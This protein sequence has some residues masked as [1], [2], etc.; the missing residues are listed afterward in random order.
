MLIYLSIFV[1]P[2]CPI[3]GRF[4]AVYQIKHMLHRWYNPPS[5]SLSLN[6]AVV[7]PRRVFKALAEKIVC[8]KYRV[9]SSNKKL[10]YSDLNPIVLTYINSHNQLYT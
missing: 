3:A 1:L 6:L 7:V 5:I 4:Y 9:L 8:R 10:A 2:N